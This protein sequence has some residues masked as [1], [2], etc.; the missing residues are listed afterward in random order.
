MM[1]DMRLSQ[2][3]DLHQFTDTTFPIK[4][5]MND[6]QSGFIGQGLEQFGALFIGKIRGHG[7]K[8]IPLRILFIFNSI[9]E[10]FHRFNSKP[11]RPILAA[12]FRIFRDLDIA[13]RGERD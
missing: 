10:F 5:D 1:R 6:S 2:I 13:F 11:K 9:D 7:L 3:Q 12:D 4:Q 8:T